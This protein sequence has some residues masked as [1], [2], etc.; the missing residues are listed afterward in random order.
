[1]PPKAYKGEDEDDIAIDM[2]TEK[3]KVRCLLSR[4]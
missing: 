4:K 3:T 2:T 1:M